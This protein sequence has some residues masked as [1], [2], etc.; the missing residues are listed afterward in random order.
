MVSDPVRRA[1]KRV[2]PTYV[3]GEDD[4]REFKRV[5]LIIRKQRARLQA[6]ER[7]KGSQIFKNFSNLSSGTKLD[8]STKIWKF[9]LE[10]QAQS[11][12]MPST[13]SIDETEIIKPLSADQPVD[14]VEVVKEE[15]LRAR[16]AGL[17]SKAILGTHPYQSDSPENYDTEMD[18]D[19]VA[20]EK[21]KFWNPKWFPEQTPE[22]VAEKRRP[23]PAV[24]EPPVLLE[25]DSL[26]EVDP[27]QS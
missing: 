24:V 19:R 5:R 10:E 12:R 27:Q 18:I 15:L 7:K 11:S 23:T 8:L 9:H 20:P 2:A 26:M 1:K 3:D 22:I 16:K 25:S 13:E 6:F 21:E 17:L 4:F 14:V